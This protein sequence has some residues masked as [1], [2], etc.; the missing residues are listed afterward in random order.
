MEDLDASGNCTLWTFSVERGT[1]ARYQQAHH[2]QG[3]AS[4]AI[5]G[6]QATALLVINTFCMA[7]AL[8]ETGVDVTCYIRIMDETEDIGEQWEYTIKQRPKKHFYNKHGGSAYSAEDAEQW[9]RDYE[10][11]HSNM[12]STG[13]K[14]RAFAP[15][16][17]SGDRLRV[18]T[19]NMVTLAIQFAQRERLEFLGVSIIRRLAWM[20]QTGNYVIDQAVVSGRYGSTTNRLRLEA[21]AVINEGP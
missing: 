12:H 1:N 2:V 16:A 8:N 18:H 19:T 15:C 7:C 10:E 9:R 5:R 20:L 11:K 6:G 17:G 21:L 14:K 3:F 13:F 4:F